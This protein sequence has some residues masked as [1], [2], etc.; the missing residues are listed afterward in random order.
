MSRAGGEKRGAAARW[1]A[2]GCLAM[3][4]AH[5]MIAPFESLLRGSLGLGVQGIQT[6]LV[7][8]PCVLQGLAEMLTFSMG[9][10]RRPSAPTEKAFHK[11]FLG[12]IFAFRLVL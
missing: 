2:E 3:P 8:T 12:C 1:T 9:K 7:Q 11:P 6:L 4:P 5:P 10:P